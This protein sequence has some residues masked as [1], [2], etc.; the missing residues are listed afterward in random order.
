MTMFL[1]SHRPAT[2]IAGWL[3]RAGLA[4]AALADISA[5][6]RE[7]ARTRRDLAGLDK[8]LLADIGLDRA[9]AAAEAEKP[10]WR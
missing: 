6:W 2:G 5:Q 9:T 8:R 10:F 1:A 4:L 7:R 3:D